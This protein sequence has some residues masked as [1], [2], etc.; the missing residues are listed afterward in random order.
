MTQMSLFKESQTEK[1]FKLLNDH[2]PHRTDEIVK[3]VYGPGCTLARVAARVGDVKRDHP[4][5]R[6]ESWKAPEDQTLH[7]YQM[8]KVEF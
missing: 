8:F 5:M 2:I 6:V 4:E 3:E 1:L 7:Y